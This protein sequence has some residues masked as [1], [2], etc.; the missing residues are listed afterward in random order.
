MLKLPEVSNAWVPAIGRIGDA[1][2][3]LMIKDKRDILEV[4]QSELNFIEQRGYRRSVRVPWRPKSAFQDSRTCLNYA[5]LDKPHPCSEC[6]LI[7]FVPGDMRSERVPCHFIPLD[8]SGE[9]IEDLELENNQHQLERALITWLR[10]R[11]KEIVTT[12]QL[13]EGQVQAS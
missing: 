6:Q 5:Y 9:T 12:R 7:D 3:I 1:E 10:A 11:I 8:Q 13:A 2:V 4:L